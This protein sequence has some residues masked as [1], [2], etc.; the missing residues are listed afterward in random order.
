MSSSI[1]SSKKKDVKRRKRSSKKGESKLKRMKK[2]RRSL[3]IFDDPPVTKKET[4]VDMEHKYDDSNAL[5]SYRP[6]ATN[7]EVKPVKQKQ[8]G[9]AKKLYKDYKDDPNYLWN[10]RVP[11]THETHPCRF[12]HTNPIIASRAG[13]DVYAKMIQSRQKEALRR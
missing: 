7:A 10:R 2:A 6:P 3:D 12:M 4:P 9:K 13:K 11:C 8:G 1:D 5:V